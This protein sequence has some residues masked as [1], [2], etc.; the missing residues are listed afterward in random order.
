MI[1]MK[2]ILVIFAVIMAGCQTFAP[3]P[4]VVEPGFR[5]YAII[6]YHPQFSDA[7]VEDQVLTRLELNGTGLLKYK[8]GQSARVQNLWWKETGEVNAWNNYSSDQVVVSPDVLKSSLQALADLGLL[9]RK[10]QGDQRTD[11]LKSYLALQVRIGNKQGF[12]LTDFPEAIKLYET[13]RARFRR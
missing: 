3:K 12:M 1:P 2:S 9:K 11:P 10:R 5:D 4:V 7:N 6:T 8:Q 13:L